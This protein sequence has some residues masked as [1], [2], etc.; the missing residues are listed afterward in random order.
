MTDKCSLPVS[1]F[2][3]A[4]SYARNDLRSFLWI[5]ISMFNGTDLSI[6]L[7]EEMLTN[8]QWSLLIMLTE[9]LFGSTALFI[10]LFH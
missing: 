2:K 3:I 10:P 9:L 6:G 1:V 4:L 7:I 5:G 8:G